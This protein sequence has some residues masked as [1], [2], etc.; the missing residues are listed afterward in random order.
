MFQLE[1]RAHGG[2]FHAADA[3]LSRGSQSEC[4]RDRLIVVQQQGRQGRARAQLISALH[5]G[6]GM[7]WIS[8]AAQAIHIPAQRS[9]GYV[10]TP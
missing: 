10:E 3:A 4:N 8:K 7:D 2:L 9:S 6:G 1:K 5:A